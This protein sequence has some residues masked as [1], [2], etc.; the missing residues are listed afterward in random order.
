MTCKI[1]GDRSYSAYC[2]KHKP[3]K[4]L[5]IFSLK[6]KIKLVDIQEIEKMKDFFQSIWR[7]RPHYSEISKEKLHPPISS[8]YFHHIIYKENCEEG[9][10][11]EANIIL[12]TVNEHQN[13]HINPE[14]YPEINRRKELLKT[15]YNL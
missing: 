6:K 7:K 15:K 8:A 9:K 5:R 14:R 13:V 4:P 11:D 10:Y 3:P 2:F 1:C 12:L